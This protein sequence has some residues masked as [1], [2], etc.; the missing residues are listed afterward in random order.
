MATKPSHQTTVQLV[1]KLLATAALTMLMFA[2]GG[3]GGGGG[4][5]GS[6]ASSA[7]STAA[8]SSASATTTACVANASSSTAT[9]SSGSSSAGSQPGWIIESGSSRAYTELPVASDD[10]INPM[11]GYH[12]WFNLE[13]VPQTS[14][15]LV[16]YNR[17]AWRDLETSQDVYDFSAVL[18][19]ASAA[20]AAGQKFAFRIAMMK[21]YGDSTFYLPA[22]LYKNAA[23]ARNC[24][25][26][27]PSETATSRT[28][29]PDWNDA[30][31]QTRA[32]K[33]LTAL[34]DQL[35]TTGV[36]L[37]WIDVGLYGQYGEWYLDSSLYGAAPPGITTITESSK[38]VFARMFM[39]VFPDEQLV[40]FALRAQKIVLGWEL[41]QSITTKPV[42]LRTDCLGRDWVLGEW[43]QSPADLALIRDQ[44]KKAP[45]VAELC[46]PDTG[47]NVV[48]LDMA[49]AQIANFHIST[50]G[51]GN[52]SNS[53]ADSSQRWPALTATQ[54]GSLLMMGREAG[55]RYVV[56]DSSVSLNGDGS[57]RI[58]ATIRNAGN[59]PSYEN[60]AVVAELVDGAGSVLAST[61]ISVDL[62]ASLGSCSAQNVDMNWN[63]VAPAAGR[64][65]IRLV[66]RHGSWPALKWATQERNGDGSLTLATVFKNN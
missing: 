20:K 9:A 44:W 11:R 41:T 45:F 13:L 54:Q 1:T 5:G 65:A 32:Q 34:R 38:Q 14:P 27:T 2:C 42:G 48:D 15:A 35:A 23:C 29:V 53:I 59:A 33:M 12:R 31:L 47:K 28:F 3:G 66:A 62:K 36:E 49:R 37:A 10:T 22:Y 40:V 50:I 63:P 8:T 64:Y 46:T 26:W 57:M 55:Y 21:G 60:W 24:G 19:K 61:P 52:F 7:A 30:W 51:N 17:Y 18:A 56:N 16:A 39:D 4:N 58:R 6:G 43:E 25:F